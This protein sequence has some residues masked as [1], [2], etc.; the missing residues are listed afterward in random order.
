MKEIKISKIQAARRHINAG[1]WMLFRKDDP[2]VIHTVAMAGFGVLR[3][4]TKNKGLKD[5][6]DSVIR[7]EKKSEFWGSF[8][9]LANFCKHAD[10]DPYDLSRGV[11][12]EI[13]D[14]LLLIA[15]MYYQNLGCMPTKEM[16]ALWAW[17]CVLHP[18][19]VKDVKIANLALGL[20]HGIR[21]VPRSEQLAIGFRCL[22]L[23]TGT[24]S[25]TEFSA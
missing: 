7:P 17:H 19:V 11:R 20:G 4:L 1:I 8:V 22:Q 9:S 16:E 25:P 5:S 15:V 18:G 24:D 23:H 14:S 2:V 3:D 21:S 12:E 6:M 10:R 13:N